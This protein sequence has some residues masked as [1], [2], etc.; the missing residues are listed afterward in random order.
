VREL[1]GHPDAAIARKRTRD[2]FSEVALVTALPTASRPAHAGS[3]A[4]A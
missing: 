2:A 4:H 1:Y 3:L